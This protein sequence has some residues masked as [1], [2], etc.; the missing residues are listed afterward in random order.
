M[1]EKNW[2][3]G[4]IYNVGFIVCTHL[5]NGKMNQR[6]IHQTL[7]LPMELSESEIKLLILEKF[8]YSL[9]VIYVEELYSALILKK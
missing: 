4:V 6:E 9:E 8:D 5:E 7:V 2:D 1:I 3:D